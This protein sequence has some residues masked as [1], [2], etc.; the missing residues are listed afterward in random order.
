[1]Y[2]RWGLD[3]D[4]HRKLLNQRQIEGSQTQA[5]S[6]TPYVRDARPKCG[7]VDA[8]PVYPSDRGLSADDVTSIL[9]W[10]EFLT[11][12]FKQDLS[13]KRGGADPWIGGGNVGDYARLKLLREI[14]ALANTQG[15]HPLLGIQEDRSVS[16]RIAGAIKPIPRCVVLAERLS[17]MAQHIDPPIPLLP[18]R[19][20]Y[21]H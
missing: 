9:G 4:R 13:S 19:V 18:A 15:G 11:T 21:P 12:E 7:V 14:V 1:M 17:Q 20:R 5:G 2:R 6:H 10:P 8:K 3:A 16:P